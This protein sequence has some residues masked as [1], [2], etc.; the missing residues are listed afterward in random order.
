M[1]KKTYEILRVRWYGN[2]TSNEG[3]F[4]KGNG[5]RVGIGR[6]SSLFGPVNV[7]TR[8]VFSVGMQIAYKNRD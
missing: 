8:I 7:F 4:P 5:D 6:Q 3:R 2:A 1:S